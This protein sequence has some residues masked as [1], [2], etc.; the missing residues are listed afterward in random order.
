[1][2]SEAVLDE[3]QKIVTR[4]FVFTDQDTLLAYSHDQAEDLSFPPQVV[5]KPQ[6]AQEISDI[7]KLANEHKIPVTPIGA[8]TGLSGAALSVFGGIGLSLER[9]NKIIEIDEKNLQVTTEPV[10]ITPVLQEAVLEKGLFYP[11]DPSSR[12]SCFI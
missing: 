10:V 9:L 5:V 2:I 4:Q 3:L 8:Q 7:L 11:V 1:M 6:S 12:G